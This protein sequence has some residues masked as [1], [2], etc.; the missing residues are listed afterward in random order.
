MSGSSVRLGWRCIAFGGWLALCFPTTTAASDTTMTL[1][2]LIELVRQNELLYDEIDVTI[3]DQYETREIPEK[4]IKGKDFGG[5]G[6]FTVIKAENSRHRYIAQGEWYRVDSRGLVQFAR[7]DQQDACELREYDGEITR[8]LR[9]GLGNIVHGRVECATPIRPHSL[10][11]RMVGRMHR[12]SVYLAGNA[13]R[14]AEAQEDAVGEGASSSEYKGERVHN[15]E[16]CYEVECTLRGAGGDTGEEGIVERLVIWLS[17]E[18]NLIPVG[19]ISYD[20]HCSTTVPLATG[21]VASWLEIAPGIWFPRNLE[22]RMLDRDALRTSGKQVM[23]WRRV[24]TVE[25]VS[26]KPEFPRS[27]FRTITFPEGTVVYEFKG[28]QYVRGYRVGSPQ[29]PNVAKGKRGSIHRWLLW[30]VGVAAVVASI[31]V[32]I[33]VRR[34]RK[35]RVC[36]AVRSPG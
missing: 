4:P 9:G 26:L 6:S 19:F 36:A 13:G 3:T 17:R 7:D 16:R 27:F 8:S 31:A 34:R 22:F 12:L 15:G 28:K 23:A 14:A 20:P 25:A 2:G 1:E 29:D 33:L 11:Y 5:A 35:E 18:R 32:V 21:N 10:F 24:Y 30:S